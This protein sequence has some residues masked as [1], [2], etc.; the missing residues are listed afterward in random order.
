MRQDGNF[1]KVRNVRIIVGV[2]VF[3]EGFSTFCMMSQRLG[4]GTVRR[5]SSHPRR[6]S[7][8]SAGAGLPWESQE[9]DRASSGI[10]RAEACSRQRFQVPP[11]GWGGVL[12]PLS[13]RRSDQVSCQFLRTSADAGRSGLGSR[14]TGLRRQ[15][16]G[17]SRRGPLGP[18]WAGFS[19]RALGPG[20]SP[21]DSPFQGDRCLTVPQDRLRLGPRCSGGPEALTPKGSADPHDPGFSPRVSPRVFAKGFLAV[22]RDSPLDCPS[23]SPGLAGCREGVTLTPTQCR[24]GFIPI[25]RTLQEKLSEIFSGGSRPGLVAPSAGAKSGGLGLAV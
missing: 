5:A 7:Q 14:L 3:L 13:G 23:F 18:Q 2:L 15:G 11:G 25:S 10:R 22:R 9:K 8:L 4:P 12:P 20:T 16:W 6:G 24:V 1:R 21:V 17:R 19:P